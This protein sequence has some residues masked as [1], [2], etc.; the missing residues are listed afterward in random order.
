MLLFHENMF[1]FE[2]LLTGGFNINLVYY[3]LLYQVCQTLYA[4]VLNILGYIK[5]W[6]EP[7]IF[8]S[9]YLDSKGSSNIYSYLEY[10]YTNNLKRVNKDYTERKFKKKVFKDTLSPGTYIIMFDRKPIFT[11]Y[12]QELDKR[13]T[14]V[15]SLAMW[16]LSSD[17]NFFNRFASEVKKTEKEECGLYIKEYGGH[18]YTYEDTLYGLWTRIGPIP[19][20]RM[21]DT[22]LDDETLKILM[23][24][25]TNFD[26]K[27]DYYEKYNIPYKLC[28]LL[29]SEPGMGKTSL[30]KSLAREFDYNL[31]AISLGSINDDLLP[32]VFDSVK[33]RSI[34]M[35]EDVDCMTENRDINGKEKKK[36]QDDA[37]D[38]DEEDR[39]TKKKAVSLS[40]FLNAL[41]GVVVSEGLIVIMTTNY[42]EKLDP[43]L[44][45]QERVHLHCK[46]EKSVEVYC[47]MFRRFFPDIPSDTMDKLQKFCNTCLEK[48][49]CLADV[50]AHCIKHLDNIEKALEI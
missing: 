49:L 14:M 48:E 20:R 23:E 35:F 22:I 5:I 29:S 42:P 13:G 50:Q 41:D 8:Q 26:K 44:I 40:G 19:K 2:A 3:Y 38:A 47:K 17:K 15:S 27:P 24:T 16:T 21:S 7:L 4:Y 46:L 43:A 36:E 37:V 9:F 45:R 31:Y 6:V 10:I 11:R 30:I 33:K 18:I 1:N 28:I 12:T 39:P 34:L 25:F 32:F